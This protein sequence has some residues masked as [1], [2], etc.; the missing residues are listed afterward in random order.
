MSCF[1]ASP[2]FKSVVKFASKLSRVAP[3]LIGSVM[4]DV[5]LPPTCSITPASRLNLAKD[6]P[7][8]T[9][10]FFKAASASCADFAPSF[11]ELLNLSPPCAAKPFFKLACISSILRSKASADFSA[12]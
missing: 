5:R 8:V 10:N 7:A 1:A 9:P 2:D 4:K 11:S 12:S 6:S 3:C